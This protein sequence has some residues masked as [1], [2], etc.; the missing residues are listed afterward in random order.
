MHDVFALGGIGLL[1][2]V[3][4]FLGAAVGLVLGHL[5][6]PLL[7][8]YIGSPVGGA[9][10][11]LAVSGLGALAGTYRHAREGRVWLSVLAFIGIPSAAGAILGV[12]L[13]VKVNRFWAHIGLGA[14]LLV[15]GIN[16]LR[17]RLPSSTEGDV[18][19]PGPLRLL[20]EVG[21]GLFLGI[22]ASVTGLMMSSLRVPMMIRLLKI[23]PKVAVGS[24]MAIG[25]LTGL[26]GA[27]TSLTAGG[28]FD[29][30][31]LA[32]V[33]PPTMLG[34]ALGARVTGRL[35]KET[36]Q[37]LLGGTIAVL[38]LVMIIEGGW[39]AT[40]ARDLQPPPHTPVEAKELEEEEDEWPDWP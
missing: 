36:V 4:S 25:F 18:R 31:V 2:F 20:G 39:K 11:N 40:R 10:T 17:A 5:R 26:V 30:A 14:V 35:R 3:L 15:M 9:S 19:L 37:R 7:I 27:V 8:A 38:G 34:S 12:L 28:D 29:L 1:S 22:L 6:L 32:F 16:M 33:G 23:D 13:F 24:N 21:I